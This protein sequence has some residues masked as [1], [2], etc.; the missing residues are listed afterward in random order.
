MRPLFPALAMFTVLSFGQAQKA[1]A[2]AAMTADEAR[3]NQMLTTALAEKNPDTRKE[4][5]AAFS[6]SA[7]REPYLTELGSALNDKDVYV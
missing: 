4:A 1:P 3:A 6:L 2:Q 7:V 5:A